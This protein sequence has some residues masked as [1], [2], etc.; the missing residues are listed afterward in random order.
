MNPF[1]SLRP[2]ERATKRVLAFFNQAFEPENIT[3]L[4]LLSA[5]GVLRRSIGHNLRYISKIGN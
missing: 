2:S 4:D 1:S 3:Q 5:D